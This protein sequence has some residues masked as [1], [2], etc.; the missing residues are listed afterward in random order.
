MDSQKS[1]KKKITTDTM[2]TNNICLNRRFHKTVMKFYKKREKNQMRRRKALFKGKEQSLKKHRLQKEKN[3]KN[4]M[5]R[6]KIV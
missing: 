6:K 1:K 4:P 2:Q 3:C 5:K